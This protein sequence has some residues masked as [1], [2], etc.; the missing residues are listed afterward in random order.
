[1]K[2]EILSVIYEEPEW[3][4]T[5][6]N[7]AATGLAV[8]LVDRDGVGSLAEAIN[9]G[10]RDS[11]PGDVDFLWIVT[12]PVFPPTMPRRLAHALT[13]TGWAAIHPSFDSNH[14]SMRMQS[15]GFRETDFVEFTAPMVRAELLLRYPLDE[16]MPYVGFDLDWS[17]RV[18]QAGWK[19]GVDDTQI[20]GHTYLKESNTPRHPATKI[21]KERRMVALAGTHLKLES[22]YGKRWR[23]VLGSKV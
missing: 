22:K 3:L 12:N 1:M 20:L 18:R 23:Y 10:V 16:D 21:R 14:T 2:T 11:V 15:A 17:Y 7:M 19:L 8:R 6:R 9:R 4:E 13:I 5:A